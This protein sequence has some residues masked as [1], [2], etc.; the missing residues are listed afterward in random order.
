MERIKSLPPDQ[1]LNKIEQLKSKYNI[2][3]KQL[4][5]QTGYYTGTKG[6][7]KK[8]KNLQTELTDQQGKGKIEGYLEPQSSIK[9][10][11]EK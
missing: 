9:T 11:K 7:D 3:S 1:Q 4:K 8:K 5:S 2:S 10:Y 6:K